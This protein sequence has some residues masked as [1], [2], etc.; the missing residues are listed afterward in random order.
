MFGHV[1]DN[2]DDRLTWLRE[3]TLGD[4]AVELREAPCGECPDEA[5]VISGHMDEDLREVV[6]ERKRMRE[7]VKQRVIEEH[8]LADK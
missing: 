4:D 3:L 1:I 5:E 7:E 6:E 2:T 8:K